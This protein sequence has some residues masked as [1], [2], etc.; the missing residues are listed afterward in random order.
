MIGHGFMGP[1]FYGGGYW[2]GGF[3]GM[4]LI[5]AALACIVFLVIWLVR[6]MPQKP[7]EG[8]EESAIDILKRRYARG[9]ISREEYERMKRDIL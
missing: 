3:I 8:E 9:E 6:R 7:E 2:L 5:A 4:L 1:G